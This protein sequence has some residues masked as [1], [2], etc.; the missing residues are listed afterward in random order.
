MTKVK[1]KKKNHLFLLRTDFISAY[2]PAYLLHH[3][4]LEPTAFSQTTSSLRETRASRAWNEIR[5]EKDKTGGW[6]WESLLLRLF[7]SQ[8]K[9]W[10]HCLLF[11]ILP[12]VIEMEVCWWI[13]GICNTEQTSKNLSTVFNHLTIKLMPSCQASFQSHII[14]TWLCIADC[15]EHLVP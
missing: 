1:K 14:K 4:S 2:S 10:R 5:A 7:H 12:S 8:M 3:A 9:W 15:I 6:V 13:S 11:E